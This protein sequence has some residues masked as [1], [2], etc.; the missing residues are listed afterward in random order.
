[1]CWQQ[2]GSSKIRIISNIWYLFLFM[3]NGAIYGPMDIALTELNKIEL[4]DASLYITQ[5]NFSKATIQL[6]IL[7]V[8]YETRQN[9][10]HRN[11]DLVTMEFYVFN[12][13]WNVLCYMPKRCVIFKIQG[14]INHTYGVLFGNRVLCTLMIINTCIGHMDALCTFVHIMSFFSV[15]LWLG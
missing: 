7:I 3:F 10:W 1:M 4:V 14:Q 2:I 11:S 15:L 8:E 13:I 6:D 9:I 12:L 5:R